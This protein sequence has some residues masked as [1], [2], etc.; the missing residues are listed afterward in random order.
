MQHDPAALA[1]VWSLL[2]S[3]R[4]SS[5]S[6]VVAEARKSLRR[7]SYLAY[8]KQQL[9]TDVDAAKRE[10]LLQARLRACG[11][12]PPR[13]ARHGPLRDQGDRIPGARRRIRA[14]AGVPLP[15]RSSR[16]A[17]GRG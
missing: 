11:A 14:A 7:S 17:P 15:R 16:R 5:S 1:W 13:P 2:V 12:P 10:K 3:C 6:S 9:L 8:I 4:S